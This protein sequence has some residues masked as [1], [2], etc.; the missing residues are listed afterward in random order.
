MLVVHA[1]SG[2]LYCSMTPTMVARPT[3]AAVIINTTSSAGGTYGLQVFSVLHE[4][5]LFPL[6]MNNIMYALK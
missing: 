5:S 6:Q 1:E 4:S 3:Q 2:M